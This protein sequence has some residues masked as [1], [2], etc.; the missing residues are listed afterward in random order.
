LSERGDKKMID[1]T[2]K[3]EE[4]RMDYLVGL[5]WAK[6]GAKYHLNGLTIRKFVERKYPEIFKPRKMGNKPYSIRKLSESY[7]VPSLR[8]SG[9]LFKDMGLKSG[10]YVRVIADEKRI[11]IV[12][13]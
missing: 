12:E 3:S 7:G 4:I 5:S 8:L 13:L 10:D 6:M 9:T 1:W 11:I 2:D